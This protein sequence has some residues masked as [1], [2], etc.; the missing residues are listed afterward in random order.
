MTRPLS[1]IFALLLHCCRSLTFLICEVIVRKGPGSAHR[2]R[3]TIVAASLMSLDDT[4]Y[5]TIIRCSFSSPPERPFLTYT[6]RLPGFQSI[7]KAYPQMSN[8][9]EF[10]CHL[11]IIV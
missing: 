8:I 2:R 3:P 6:T 1:H 9:G 5:Y 10:C 11:W 4:E 7:C